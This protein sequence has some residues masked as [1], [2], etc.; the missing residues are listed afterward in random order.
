MFRF[1]FL[2]FLLA[3]TFSLPSTVQAQRSAKS[4]APE[5]LRQLSYPERVRVIENEYYEQSGGRDIPDDQLEFYLDSVDS[6]WTFSRIRQDMATSLGDNNNGNW[7][8][9]SNWSPRNVICS[10]V[11]NR[12]AEC[13]TP[14]RGRAVV[15]Q[16]ISKTRCIEGNNW[17]QRQGV[18]WVNKG[19]RAQFGEVSG[20]NGWDNGNNNG[21]N[22]GDNRITCESNNSQYR[23]CRTNFRGPAQLYRKLSNSSCDAGRDWGTRSGYVWVRNG[24]RAEF[25]DSYGGYD[26]SN[27]NN[28]GNYG[29]GWGNNNYTVTCSSID[30]NYKTCAW[31][32]RY[33]S[34]RLIQQLSRQSC[35][36]GRSWGYD[37]RGLWVSDGC[38]AKFGPR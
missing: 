15:T 7:N 17:D 32:H 8:P 3:G 6:G 38:R 23:E 18:I 1:V 30:G 31:D 37:N 19:C 20:G 16:Q 4:Y 34:P 28:N 12:Y 13:R 27:G 5:N 33:G 9:D 21:N 2:M 11:K 24:C 14:F 10:S 25:Y 35:I 22:W 29:N 26:N 36:S